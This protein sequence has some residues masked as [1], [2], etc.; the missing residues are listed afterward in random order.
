ML[1]QDTRGGDSLKSVTGARVFG[2]VT[3]LSLLMI[4]LI[5]FAAPGRNAYAMGFILIM[6]GFT[7]I[8][9]LVAF[10]V[11]KG[12]QWNRRSR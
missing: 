2:L 7:F 9:G 4:L 6:L 8:G 12:L 5:V 1:R 3:L 10:L 11:S